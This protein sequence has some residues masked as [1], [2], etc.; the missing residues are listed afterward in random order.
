MKIVLNKNDSKAIYVQLSNQLQTYIAEKKLQP[1]TMLPNIKMI[2]QNASVSIKTAERAL[3]KLIETGICTRRPKKGTFVANIIRSPKQVNK[4]KALSCMAFILIG[5][6]FATPYHA[7]VL[8]GAEEMASAKG[9]H[10]ICASVPF[11]APQILLNKIKNIISESNLQAVLLG[12]KVDNENIKS[13]VD[14]L[15][16]NI[17][18]IIMGRPINGFYGGI[19]H[20]TDSNG[21][22]IRVTLQFLKDSGHQNIAFLNEPLRWAWNREIREAFYSFMKIN[23]LPLYPKA[24]MD[25]LPGDTMNDGYKGTI[26]ILPHLKKNSIS[27]IACGTDK[28]AR[29]AMKAL[30]ENGFKIP[31]DI[32]VIGCGNLDFC[33]YLEPPL[34]SVDQCEEEKGREGVLAA[35]GQ[36]Q[37]GTI[38]RIPVKLIERETTDIKLSS[39][40]KGG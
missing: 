13:I 3:N 9:F 29:G 7:R 4:N 2:A 21:L 22:A 25:N 39:I 35:T 20:I 18:M 27:A 10:L 33:E 17:S 19:S 26:K 30:K 11:S 32:N 5:A 34:T 15:G 14:L 16:E 40:R 38:I 8:K 36:Y 24:I 6:D 28:L 23:N 31:E 12:G 1:G 37:R